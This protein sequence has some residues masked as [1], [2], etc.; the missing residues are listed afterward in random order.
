M[1]TIGIPTRMQGVTMGFR[2]S[3]G[4]LYTY[5]LK[6]KIEEQKVTIEALRDDIKALKATI[7]A[8]THHLLKKGI[9]KKAR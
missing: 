6:R 5:T 3:D 4:T 2:D 1:P 9:A 8:M 7:N